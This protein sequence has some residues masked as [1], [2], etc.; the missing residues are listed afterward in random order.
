MVLVWLNRTPWLGLNNTVMC[1]DISPLSV[2]CSLGHCPSVLTAKKSRSACMQVSSLK[3]PLTL[4]CLLSLPQR[5]EFLGTGQYQTKGNRNWLSCLCHIDASWALAIQTP[6][7]KAAL[8]AKGD[9]LSSTAQVDKNNT[10][11]L[12]F[13]HQK[14]HI[15]WSPPEDCLMHKW[16][17]HSPLWAREPKSYQLIGTAV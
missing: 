11:L 13:Y 17:C 9:F 5:R 3:S 15:W 8:V 2:L 1:I 10:S 4:I 16:C 14:C 12:F 6:E 7:L